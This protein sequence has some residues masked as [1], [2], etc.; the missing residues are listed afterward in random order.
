[1]ADKSLKYIDLSYT[2]SESDKSIWPGNPTIKL[3]TVYEGTDNPAGCFISMFNLSMSEHVGTHM[4][5]PYHFNPTGWKTDEIPLDVLVNVPAIVVDISAKCE[6]DPLATLESSDLEDWVRIHGDI[7]D[8]C[9]V[10]L[11]SGWGQY[12]YSDPDKFLGSSVPDE[13]LLQF[14][15]FGKSGIDWLIKNTSF[16]G[17]GVDT[18][19]IELG[20]LQGCYVH[21]TLT[22]HNKYGVECLANLDLLPPKDF[23][24]TTLPLKIA[25]GSGGPC[26]VVATVKK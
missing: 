7:P 15:G 10:L 9:L 8:Q 20:R 24:V 17:V 5:A 16:V 18:L 3:E 2:L 1:M 14:P 23:N 19:S 4:D 26:R 25:G 6:K 22:A 21:R 11:R 12:Y 13:S